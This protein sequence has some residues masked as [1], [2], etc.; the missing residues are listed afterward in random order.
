MCVYKNKN[1]DDKMINSVA[2]GK[3]THLRYLN[4]V[5]CISILSI[6]ILFN[7]TLMIYI[8]IPFFIL[9]GFIF[10]KVIDEKYILSSSGIA[11]FMLRDFA[12]ENRVLSV[13]NRKVNTELLQSVF[14]SEA[15]YILEEF[16]INGQ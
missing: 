11:S 10:E 4:Y 3:E 16:G 15:L 2:I 1:I 12:L 9:W 13:S 7:Y 8:F 6:L 5:G 14:D